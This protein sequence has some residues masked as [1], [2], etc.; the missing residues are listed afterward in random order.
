MSVSSRRRPRRQRRAA[1]ATRLPPARPPARAGA[2][3]SP[4]RPL[5]RRG[6]PGSGSG[7]GAAARVFVRGAEERRDPGQAAACSP[8][9]SSG[10]EAEEGASEPH[11]D[12]LSAAPRRLHFVRGAGRGTRPGLWPR[13]CPLAWPPRGGP[14][15]APLTPPVRG[16][17]AGPGR[18]VRPGTPGAAGRAGGRRGAGPGPGPDGPGD[19][20]RGRPQRTGG[21]DRSAGRWGSGQ[22]GRLRWGVSEVPGRKERI[23]FPRSLVHT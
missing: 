15:G 23:W 22:P 16:G 2:R 20:R 9:P 7:R 10:P 8:P 12:P 1:G 19:A 6:R 21:T 14:R 17:M 18:F 13:P 11:L 3:P 4:A 5:P